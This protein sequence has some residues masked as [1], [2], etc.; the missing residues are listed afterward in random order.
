LDLEHDEDLDA[1]H[2]PVLA[3]ALGAIERANDL[4]AAPRDGMESA[5]QYEA[6]A[7]EREPLVMKRAPEPAEI[8][9]KT[10]L[11]PAEAPPARRDEP[12]CAG[13]LAEVL[14]VAKRKNIDPA[15]LKEH[16]SYMDLLVFFRGAAKDERVWVQGLIDAQSA[17]IG[18]ALSEANVRIAQLEARLAQSEGRLATVEAKGAKRK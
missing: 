13:E 6:L 16:A 15:F 17:R 11:Q 3:R 8:V 1:E 2:D 10:K 4:I 12:D 18:A 14:E 9:R 7:R 5:A